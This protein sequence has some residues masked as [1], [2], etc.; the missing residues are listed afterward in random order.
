VCL[1]APDVDTILSKCA[2]LLRAGRTP[3]VKDVHVDWGVRNDIV[4]FVKFEPDSFPNT[5]PIIEQVPRIIHDIHAGVRLSV[6]AIVSL[7][8]LEVPKRVILR[9]KLADSKDSFE[10]VVPIRSVQLTQFERQPFIHTLA[11]L[12]LIREYEALG[13]DMHK[14]AIVRLGEKYQLTSRY[15]SFIARE[16]SAGRG[17]QSKINFGTWMDDLQR[18]TTGQSVN[19]S[20]LNIPGGWR[21]GQRDDQAQEEEYINED[22]GYESARTFSTLSSLESCSCSDWSRPSTP[23]LDNEEILAQNQASPRVV[24]IDLAPDD[25]KSVYVAE[26]NRHSNAS[27]K[28]Q[29]RQPPLKE[30]VLGLLRTQSFDGSFEP[31]ADLER[32]LGARAVL[33]GQTLGIKDTK[34]W[35]TALF[36]AYVEKN[37][38]GQRELANDILTKAYEYLSGRGD[39]GTL[40]SAAKAVL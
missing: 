33:E 18:S 40:V 29:N 14:A 31:D 28:W 36:I 16:S 26:E 10:L 38:P 19:G 15:T 34:V 37:L 23:P 12:N 25:I 30:E 35:A 27:S 24:S 32:I 5:H 21:E 2:R 8:T 39:V 17:L 6:F 22:E 13:S 7:Q 20:E 1:M 9:G 3:F 11:A 4:P